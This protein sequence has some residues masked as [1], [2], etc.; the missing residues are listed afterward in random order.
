MSE[1]H[2]RGHRPDPP[3][4]RARRA[5]FHILKSKRGFAEQL[6]LSVDLSP[7]VTAPG[8]PGILDQRDSSSCEGHAHAGAIATRFAR[9]GAP[10]ALPSPIGI[11]TLARC[12]G[13][14]PDAN[15]NLPALTDDGT[16]PSLVVRAI[17]EWGVSSATTWGHYPADTA[18]VNQEPTQEELERSSDFK[19]LGAYFMQS[20]GDQLVID[21]MT[22]LAAGYPVSMG[23]PASGQEFNAY[24]GGILGALSGPVD[25]ANYIVGYTL[26]ATGAYSQVVMTS[27]NSW[28]SGWGEGGMYRFGRALVDQLEDCC[29]VDVIASAGSV[30]Q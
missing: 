27:V 13:R 1:Q 7:F 21:I 25:H 12:I 2:G 6:P 20:V 18:T 26:P 10:I 8:G 19:L 17:Q 23:L 24:R 3:D 14:Q 16:E 11:Y 5:G 4:V 9:N 15:G 22:A 30:E 29:A 28:S